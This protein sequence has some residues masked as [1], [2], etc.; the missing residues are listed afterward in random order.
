MALQHLEK[1][2]SKSNLP[3]IKYHV[4][5]AYFK[6]RDWVRG[7]THLQAAVKIAPNLPEAIEAMAFLSKRTAQ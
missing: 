1:A 7:G 4:A 6:M 3:V 2:A 5:M